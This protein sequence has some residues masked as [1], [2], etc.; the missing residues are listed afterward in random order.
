MG[1][2]TFLAQSGSIVIIHATK[3]FI[4]PAEILALSRDHD[5]GKTKF[6]HQT[7]KEGALGRHPRS[8]YSVM[9]A[10]VSLSP[11]DRK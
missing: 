8:S 11:K 4:L 5:R 6:F 7:P 9:A 10:A 3:P 2:N 1:M